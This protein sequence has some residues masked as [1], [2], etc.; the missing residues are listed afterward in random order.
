MNKFVTD[1]SVLDFF[2]LFDAIDV[3]IIVVNG[4]REI[5]AWNDWL[6]KF[7]FLNLED[8]LLSP[9]DSIFSNIPP[10]LSQVI[11]DAL[12]NGM[13]GYL[14]ERLNKHPLALF[15]SKDNKEKEKRI[16]Q[17]IS[18]RPFTLKNE[19]M[20]IVQITDVTHDAERTLSLRDQA[21]ELQALADGAK[22]KQV[23]LS[24][25]IDNSLDAI[26]SLK[27]KWSNY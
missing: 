16:H 2:T 10:R 25:I 6:E 11:S 27:P 21:K 1:Q 8:V 20:C 15:N 17:K 26:I 24:S 13:R 9:L 22:E 4:N 23:E 7:S 12:K 14:S 5:V 18:V 19:R 3:G